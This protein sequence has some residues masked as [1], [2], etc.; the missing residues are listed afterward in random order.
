[1]EAPSDKSLPLTAIAVGAID[2]DDRRY[3]V[4]AETD[5]ADLERSIARVGLL[6]P[7]HLIKKGHGWRIVSGFRRLRACAA[8]GWD[9]V[10]AR[11]L[12][13]DTA[14]AAC[15]LVAI[16]ANALERPLNL[17]EQ[18]R[19]SRLLLDHHADA[20]DLKAAA[21]GAGLPPNLKLLRQLSALADAPP[22]L[23]EAMTAGSVQLPM[24]LELNGR[25]VAE[26]EAL[27][28][29]FQT[30]RPSLNRQRELIGF[31][32][33]IARRDDLPV[34]R[35]LA[36]AVDTADAANPELERPIRYARL[37]SFLRQRRYPH[38]VD[39]ERRRETALRELR[40]DDEMELIPPLNFEGRR[41]QL[42]LFFA[43]RADLVARTQSC[44]RLLDAP[45]L[46]DLLTRS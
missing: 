16:A 35:V 21:R 14:P 18:V 34:T 2:L 39:A 11:C 29:L 41:F 36:E 8:L 31:L 44:Q 30:L 10:Q 40:L 32:D 19:A 26:A 25:P 20:P 42:R 5:T 15:A 28:G 7:P 3:Q 1:M 27:A 9:A 6:N 23:F 24:A 37:R 33:D 38:L 45:P 17:T 13:P 4:S 12:P 43:D 22:A 46:R